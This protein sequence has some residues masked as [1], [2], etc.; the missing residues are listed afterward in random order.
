MR[1]VWAEIDLSA[2][3]HN[4][5]EVRRIIPSHSK[6][7]AI[8]KANAYGHGASAVV[9]KLLE[10]GAD[11]LGVAILDEALELREQGIKAPILVL[12]YTGEE[13]C[14]LVVKHDITQ[15]VFSLRQAKSL[16]KA[17]LSLHKKAK[18]H[19]KVDTGMGRIGFLATPQAVKEAEEI[20]KLPGLEVEGIFTHLAN[21]DARDKTYSQAQLDK[22]FWFVSQLEKAGIH[23]KYKH[24]ANS[25]AIIDLPQAHLDLVRPGI[26]LYGLYPSHEVAKDKVKLQPAMSLKTRIVHLK[27]VEPGTSISYG[28]TYVTKSKARIATLPLGYADG[29]TRLLS[30]KGMALV[31]GTRVPVVGRVCMDQC[32]L[33]VTA[34]QGVTLGD[35]VVLMGRQGEAIISADEIAELIGTI[36]YEVVCM[37]SSRVPRIYV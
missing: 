31:H 33:D 9:P 8:V 35:E 19:I 3:S 36:N 2:I 27:E 37:I 28:C 15:T 1:P 14:P 25:A 7:M 12:G 30:N 17:A 4:L 11:Y 32:M 6:I 34:V 22:F 20:A 24:A 29:Y 21:A 26:M 10:A 23:I 5:Q 16:S 18:I 13:N